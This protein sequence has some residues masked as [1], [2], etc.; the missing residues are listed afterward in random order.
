MRQLYVAARPAR[1]NK[2]DIGC[3]VP[4]MEYRELVPRPELALLLDRI[5]TLE[6][7]AAPGEPPE[8]VLPDGRPEIVIH[9]GDPF[10]RLEGADTAE[11]QASLLYAGQLSGQLLLRP[12]GRVAVL[13]L[14]FH[15]HGAAAILPMPQHELAG[16]P[17]P[18]DGLSPRLARALLRVREEA[19]DLGSAAKLAQEIVLRHANEARLDP[20]VGA[21]V[22]S[23]AQTRGRI[24]IDALAA[25]CGVT[26]RHL[27]RRFLAAVGVTPKRLARIVRFQHALQILGCDSSNSGPRPG[28][29][30]AAAC[31]YADQSHFIRD[32]RRLAGC[33][34][35]EHLLRQGELTGFFIRR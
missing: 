19:P 20:R 13:G 23:I 33:S 4:A 24:G 27:E 21:A 12:A 5:W 2:C 11:R 26:C 30:T 1:L 7:Y 14:R 9:L 35:R 25:S 3:S 8:P 17:Q 10:E 16:A 29:D 22:A 6:G 31:G 28:T 32:F 18:L 15:P 34:P